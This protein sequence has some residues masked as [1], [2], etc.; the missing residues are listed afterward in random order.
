MDSNSSFILSYTITYPKKTYEE[1]VGCYSAV[2]ILSL[3]VMGIVGL[4]VVKKKIEDF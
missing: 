3:S 2:F 1:S 4:V